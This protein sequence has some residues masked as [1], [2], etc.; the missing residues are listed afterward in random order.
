MASAEKRGDPVT[1]GLR[2]ALVAPAQCLDVREQGGKSDDDE[3]WR[4]KLGNCILYSI[5]N[6]HSPCGDK[7]VFGHSRGSHGKEATW[8]GGVVVLSGTHSI[9]PLVL[10]SPSVERGDQKI[11]ESFYRCHLAT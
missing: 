8:K 3:A 5:R 2:E 9:C 11:S 10:V 6:V 1:A 7:R 4:K